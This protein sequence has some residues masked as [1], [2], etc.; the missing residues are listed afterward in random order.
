MEFDDR[1][2]A[3]LH[4]ARKALTEIK[5]SHEYPICMESAHDI[6]DKIFECIEQN[7]IFL[8]SIPSIFE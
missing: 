6:A 8:D 5:R 3:Q 1:D 7:G 2:E 4:V